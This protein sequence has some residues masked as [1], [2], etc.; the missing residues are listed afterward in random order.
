MRAS[1]PVSRPADP[2]SRTFWAH[3]DLGGLKESDPNARWQPLAQHL[4]EV[5][6]IAER[7]AQAARPLDPTF[8]QN[9]HTT[10][11]LHD[12]G[13]YAP[14]FHQ[15]IRGETPKG[16]GW[17]RR[18]RSGSRIGSA[19][20]QR[21]GLRDCRPSKARSFTTHSSHYRGPQLTRPSTRTWPPSSD[22][23]TGPIRWT[24]RA[25]I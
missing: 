2:C 1:V 20:S 8:H 17:P 5:A 24:R 9:A 23:M 21:S 25:K 14:S 3:S 19:K 15:M 7:I 10:G 4:R 22:S 18:A 6:R 12:I 16:P 11:V 13:K